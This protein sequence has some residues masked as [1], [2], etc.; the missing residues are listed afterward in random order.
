MIRASLLAIA[1]IAL[2]LPEANAQTYVA[3]L[4]CTTGPYRVRLPKTY[5]ALR[6]LAPLKRERVLQKE[7]QDGHTTVYRELRFNGLELE[8]VT[9]S[10]KPNQYVLSSAVLSTAAWRI[11]GQLRVGT[12]A[13]I[14]L[15]GLA[16]QPYPN[17]GELEFNGD[18]DSI[19]ATL[20]RGRILD[21]EYSCATE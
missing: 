15:K 20:S 21:V 2:L 11:G 1:V 5:R 9:Y 17:D 12:A 13:R 4:S 18:A 7:E 14:A 8:L 16:P 19:R 6:V 10:N 3:D